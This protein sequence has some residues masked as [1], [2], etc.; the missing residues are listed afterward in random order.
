MEDFTITCFSAPNYCY[1]CG[2]EAAILQISSNE[3]QVKY[4]DEAS[5]NEREKPDRIV[6][7]Y[8]L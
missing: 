4:F 8:F 7:P 6:A 2:N 5:D 3:R 1:R